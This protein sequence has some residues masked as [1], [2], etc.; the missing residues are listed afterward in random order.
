MFFVEADVAIFRS[1]FEALRHLPAADFRFQIESP[2]VGPTVDIS[3]DLRSGCPQLVT[4]NSG[5]LLFRKDADDSPGSDDDSS[6]RPGG[7]AAAAGRSA[8][9]GAGGTG[10]GA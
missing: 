2:A 5:Q 9:G 3:E 4:I 8:G 7:A 10:G 1:P 6:D